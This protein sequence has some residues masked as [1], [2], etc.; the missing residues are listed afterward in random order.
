[1]Y[2]SLRD[3]LQHIKEECEF[4]V[5]ATAGKKYPDVFDDDTLKKSCSPQ[6]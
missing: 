5:K 2:H 3:F 1:M 6:H 4:L